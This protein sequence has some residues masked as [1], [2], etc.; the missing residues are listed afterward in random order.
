MGVAGYLVRQELRRRTRTVA[1][2]AVLIALVTATVLA[3]IAGGRRAGSAFDRYLEHYRPGDAFTFGGDDADR[4]EI[5][6]FRSV[7]RLGTLRFF[8]TQPTAADPNEDFYIMM[9]SVDGLV[10]YD[11]MR[12]VVLDGRMPSPN[13]P[14]EVALSEHTARRLGYGMGDDVPM[15]SWASSQQDALESGNEPE[16]LGPDITLTV[17]GLVREPADIGARESDLT[18][19]WLTPA[20]NE[21]YH[22]RL[23]LFG[24]GAIVDIADGSSVDAFTAELR[25][26]DLPVEVD[27]L[28]NPEGFRRAITPITD[29]TANGLFV[30]AAV[31]ALAG[32][33]A[34]AQA[35]V[36]TALAAADD[37]RTLAAL[38]CRATGRHA[39]LAAPGAVAALVGAALGTVTAMLAS[40]LLPFGIARRADPDPGFHVDLPVLAIGFA[41]A[42]IAF[43]TATAVAAWFALRQQTA[44]P[45]RTSVNSVASTAAAA[46]APPPVVTGLLF[47]FSRAGRSS[48]APARSALVGTAAGVLGVAAALVFAASYDRLLEEPRLFGWGWDANIEGADLSDLPDGADDRPALLADPDVTGVAE[49]IYQLALTIDGSPASGQSILELKGNIEPVIVSGREPTGAREIA[50]GGTT[51]ERIG[52]DVGDTVRLAFA[53]NDESSFT[54]VGASAFPTS[55][56][57][58]SAS[59]GVLVTRDALAQLGWTVDDDGDWY[60]NTAVVLAPSADPNEIVKRYTDLERGAEVRL[61]QPS[62]EIERLA[63]IEQLPWILAGFLVMLAVLAVAHAI[64]VTVRR[65]RTDLAILRVLGF[66]GRQVRTAVTVQVV[67]LVAVGGTAGLVLGIVSGRQLWRLVISGLELPSSP[68]IPVAALVLVPLV[69]FTVA[70]LASALPR[71][72]A[73]RLHPVEALR[74]E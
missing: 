20:F 60:R 68:A 40:P 13:A 44:K 43:S 6:G 45:R 53:N 46:S 49:V 41:G 50:V 14:H 25:A 58:G 37:D 31:V 66:S 4:E 10:P 56:D 48:S 22:G 2:L 72:A 42:L 9:S 7:D 39:R 69:T 54:V 12:P 51:L 17:V 74:T 29:T 70:H 64:A 28:L 1:L 21:R 59:E 62:G 35:L 24:E 73:T 65:R 11:Y 61:P 18:L 27:P 34:V 32:L 5:A 15:L 30:F 52:K 19:T 57:G 16:P 55:E 36:R 26:S 71:R 8:A 47:A 63:E 23:A 33:V 67:S 38:G 3:S